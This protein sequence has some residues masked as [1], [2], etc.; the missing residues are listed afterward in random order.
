MAT[1]FKK[2]RRNFRRKV[3]GQS[4]SDEE[5][6]DQNVAPVED[7]DSKDSFESK[8]SSDKPKKSKKKKKE[9]DIASSAA[10][11]FD[12]HDSEGD[13]EVFKVK[14]SSH[15]K[16]LAKQLKKE[17]EKEK[18]EESRRQ[19]IKNE[20]EKTNS[21]K[22]YNHKQDE[23]KLRQ[24][25]EEFRTLN[26]DEA[27][28]M[29]E[30]SD[31]EDKG[32][33]H[34]FI[35]R[36]EIPDASVIHMIRKKR[37]LARDVGDFVPLEDN[38]RSEKSSS[39]LVRDD[40]NDRS[41][42]D[43][44][45]GR[46]DFSINKQAIERQKMKDDFLAAEHDLPSYSNGYNSSTYNNNSQQQ[47]SFQPFTSLTKTT[48]VSEITIEAI[49]RRLKE[50]LDS[51]E[52]VS[53]RHLQDRDTLVTDIED[54]EKSIETCQ[55]SVQGME[56]RYSF[57]Q[58]MRGYV[59][60]LV[61]CLNEKVPTINDLETRMN[62]LLKNQA[63]KL[64]SRR[65][66]DV[67]DQCQD[68]MT[69]KSQ[70]VM[71]T[72]EGQARQRR[73]AERE[74][75]RARRRRAREG[76]DI[77]GHHDGLS[78]D[79]E[80][81]QSE[82]TKFN[83][84][85]DSIMG[86]RERL[87]EDVVEDFSEVDFVREKFEDWKTKYG[88]TYREAYIGLCLPK[89]FNPFIRLYLLDWNPLKARC[90]DFEEMKWYEIL[91]ENVWDPLST[92]QTSRLVNVIQKIIRDYPTIHAKNKQTQNLL[93]SLVTRMKKTLDDDVFMPLYPKSVVENRTSG[94][95]VFFTDSC[96]HVSR[97]H[98]E[99]AG[100]F[101]SQIDFLVSTANTFYTESNPEK[102]RRDEIKQ[103]SK[104]LKPRRNFRRKVVGQSD[105]DEEKEDQNV[106]PVED[107]D[108]KD[109]FE[110][111]TSSDKPK[112][113]KKKK[114]EK[115]IASSAALSFDLHDSEGDGEVF[116]VKKSS[117]SKRLA[118]QL[119]KEKEKEKEEESRRQDIK[120]EQ[121]K[122]NS[123]KEYNHKQDEEKLRQLREEFRT[124]NGDE[125]AAMDEDSDDEDKGTLHKF[126]HR[127]EIPDASVIHMIRKKRQLARDV[128]D[129]VPLEDNVRS[130]KSSSRLVRDDDND[131]S[132]EDDEEGR[133]DF[134][135]NKQAIE[136]QKMKDDF[137]AA[138]HDL[139]S[140]SNGYN[141]STYNNNSQQQSSFQ[142]FTS[143]TKTTDVSEITIEA[144][145]RRLKERL[146]SMEEVSRRH[147]QDRD[148]LVTDIEDTEKSIETCQSSVQGMEERYS[149]FQEMRGYVR[150]LVDC[151][152]EKV[153][154][155]N[156]LETRMNNLLKN[157]AQK[158]VSR[159]QQD[160]RDQCQDYMTS[161][162]QIVMETSEGQARQRRVAEREARRARR[163]RA[164]E[165]KDIKG[166][167][168]G[169]SSDDEESQSEITKFNVEKDSIMGFRER[170]FEDVV[171][172]FS[173]V[174]FVREKFEDWKTKYG[175][176]YREAYIGLC[177][178]KLF[179]PFIRL[180][181]LDW[182]PLK[183]R[184]K[185]FEEMKWYESLIFFGFKSTDIL[186][187]EDDDIK[188][189]PGIVEKVILPK[190]NFLTENVWDPL[191]TTQTSR[192]VNVIQKIIRDYPTIHA[193]NKQ[194]QN[195]LHSLVTRMKKT[196]DDDVFMP[197]YPKSVVENRTSG[198]AV[199]FH[200]QLWTCIKL[201][202]N[203]LSWQDILSVK[204]LQGL[205]IISTFPKQW[206]VDLEGDKTIPQLQNLSRFLVSTANTFY[207]ES[208]PEK[209]RRDEIK[210]I[211]KMLVNI[212]S[213]DHALSLPQGKSE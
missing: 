51:M 71:E 41:D 161:K 118:K 131:R 147:L 12:L 109:S 170:L 86:L 16:R 28:A 129:F 61:D 141:S 53:R 32:T 116:K 119:K 157:Q 88:E 21:T 199:F 211:S 54:T 94:S 166:H 18:E 153:P 15:S 92:T 168:D 206:F 213:M 201:L 179:N 156:D 208:N 184:C 190:L 171:E 37:Q 134:S 209:D 59:R 82:I 29:D 105:S 67:R 91:T 13:G 93:H 46:I 73:V 202:G 133:I 111:K 182:N 102:D 60:D 132:D 33:L 8:T 115:D 124:L 127:G 126:I 85:K 42:E 154:T 204:V 66:Q 103:I 74:A 188:L 137:L 31:D 155:I 80:E 152:N 34:K 125:A 200:R 177:L 58:E 163:R 150:D 11:S 30:D 38:V 47:S 95:A 195:L 22:E 145:K 176:T 210:Q 19:D 100:Y 57:F 136:R 98:F 212:H 198:S 70:I 165:G 63:Q 146:D 49:K 191:S 68:Y 6:E 186:Q 164:R 139:P 151:L 7:E 123:T 114:K 181:L 83:V 45:E 158:L 138:E 50:R 1:I 104:M 52:E 113:S 43:D 90:K 48:D 77:K 84:E 26:G 72:S 207:T 4:D 14:K 106:A 40:D 173:E 194:T 167:H 27:A 99:L 160:V 101:V 197:L 36:G 205:A 78:S 148:T 112:K 2:P 149:F 142:P 130:E 180:Y 55:S 89:L 20:Q 65:Q 159:R 193:K 35:H 96:G 76:K 81:S 56:E 25:R 140:Y 39:R 64:V 144:I 62:N 17:K 79:D 128:G 69:S 143:L 183:A 122:T 121:E 117:H 10:L 120:N 135:I 24:L 169:L 75:R 108:S 174:D 175:E 162:S 97:K 23:E 196:L 189:I 203:I 172:D 5:K 107:E 185:D 187:I 192:L 178:P 110:S 44:E 87:F 9:K 3:V